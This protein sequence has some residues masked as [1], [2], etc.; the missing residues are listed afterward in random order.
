MLFSLIGQSQAPI[1]KQ[2]RGKDNSQLKLS[3]IYDNYSD[4][5][6][7][8]D[9]SLKYDKKV[10]DRW[11]NK[12][13]SRMNVYNDSTYNFTDYS[14]AFKLFVE[15]G[16]FCNQEDISNWK[17]I[18][19]QYVNHANG[20]VSAVYY[21]PTEDFYLLGAREAGLFRSTDGGDHWV[22]VTD[23]LPYPVIGIR[24]IEA[25]P[26]PIF[27]NKLVAITGDY[28]STI[29]QQNNIL[30]SSDY[31][32][33]W[34]IG[35][36]QY[37]ALDGTI[38][39]MNQLI[40]IAFCSNISDLLIG[41][42]NNEILLSQDGGITWYQIDPPIDIFTSIS[43]YESLIVSGDKAHLTMKPEGNLNTGYWSGDFTYNSSTASW[44][45][46]WSL[47]RADDL[48][49]LNQLES[50]S[51]N[52]TMDPS[53]N[54][55]QIGQSSASW[56]QH[57]LNFGC[58]GSNIG[59]WSFIKTPGWSVQNNGNVD[60][61]H[62]TFS[63]V[64]ETYDNKEIL[65]KRYFNKI[66]RFLWSG[67]YSGEF[68]LD[69]E[70]PKGA[71][72][73]V[74]VTDIMNYW[75][76]SNHPN[77]V[78]SLP[79]YSEE[80]FDKVI[81]ESPVSTANGT[82]IDA[83]GP[84][85]PLALDLDLMS[86]TSTGGGSLAFYFILE[87][88]PTEY[89]NGQFVLNTFDIDYE[90]VDS[91]TT[92]IFST[93]E[94]DRFFVVSKGSKLG[95][96]NVY[97]TLDQGD[98]YLK[99]T[100]AVISTDIRLAKHLF[101]ASPN[102]E[103]TY[104]IGGL[105]S[106][107][108]RSSG[109][110]NGIQTNQVISGTNYVNSHDDFRSGKGYDVNGVDYIVAGNDGG[111]CAVEE[112]NISP[113]PQLQSLNGDIIL[114]MIYNLDVHEKTDRIL[115]GLQDN[116]TRYITEGVN[117]SN[118]I[119]GGDGSVA[120][121]RR[122]QNP[123]TSYSYVAGDPQTSNYLALKDIQSG[124]SLLPEIVDDNISI[125]AYIGMRLEEYKL[126]PNRFIA[127][128]GP[129][130]TGTA[131]VIV[132][133]DPNQN[134]PQTDKI[135]V[136]GSRQIESIA[137]CQNDPMT[138]YVSDGVGRD[139]GLTKLYKTT[140]DGYDWVPVNATLTF[141]NHPTISDK[142]LK[143]DVKWKF[144]NAIGIDH[145]NPD[146]VYIGMSGIAEINGVVTNEYF[147]VLR[148]HED[149]ANNETFVDWSEGL[150]A[151][152]VNYLLPIES[153]NHIV[154]C[155]T[156]AGV[157]Y[158]MDGMDQWECFSNNFAKTRIT[159]LSYN[160]CSKQL[161][162]STYGR[163]VW[164]TP[165]N[166]DT[167][168]TYAKEVIGNEIWNT[169]R[170][171]R[172][173]VR[174]KTGSTLTIQSTVHIDADRRFIVEPG[175]KLI[176]DG[177]TL[178]NDCNQY[179]LGIEVWGDGSL[180]QDLQN[181]GQVITK[182]DAKIEFA[183]EAIATWKRGDWSTTGGVVT[184]QDTEFANNRTSVFFYPYHSYNP[185]NNN[186]LINLGSISNCTFTWNDEY[187]DIRP[188]PAVV[189]YHVN[190]PR[191]SGSDFIDS[192]PVLEEGDRRPTGI[193]SLDAGYK[194]IARATSSNQ[195]PHD[196]FEITGG[197]DVNNFEN[198]AYGIHA[199]NANTPYSITM[200][201][202]K[203]LNVRQSAQI[204]AVDNAVI[205]RNLVELTTGRP[206]DIAS[207][208]GIGINECT[209]FFVEG[210][211]FISSDPSAFSGGI[212]TWDTGEANNK[213]YR[214]YST[215]TSLANY[216]YG[217]NSNTTFFT[218]NQNP[219]GLT[220]LVWE[221]NH[222]TDNQFDEANFAIIG[223]PG[224]GVKLYQGDYENPAGN[225]FTD[226]N[227]SSLNAQLFHSDSEWMKYFYFDGNPP[228]EPQITI[229]DFNLIATPI[230]NE[231]SSSFETVAQVDD[232]D[233]LSESSIAQISTKL[234]EVQEDRISLKVELEENLA[235][236]DSP[237]LHELVAGLTSKNKHVVRAE[238]KQASPYLSMLL[239]EKLGNKP[240]SIFN[241][242]WYLELIQLNIEVAR[243]DNFMSFLESLE[244]PLSAEELN[245]IEILRKK[246]YTDR[247]KLEMQIMSLTEEESEAYNLLIA[248][249][250]SHN[251]EIDWEAFENL[252]LDRN[253]NSYYSE[254]AD[255]YLGEKNIEECLN[256]L[257]LIESNI[258][259]YE[260][261]YVQKEM[262]DYVIFKRYIL[263]ITNNSGIVESLSGE[264]I[265]KLNFYAEQSTGRAAIQA[266]NILCF[267][268]GNCNELPIVLPENETPLVLS[269]SNNEEEVTLF[270]QQRLKIIP[271]PSQGTF[272]LEVPNN[273]QIESL[274]ILDTQGRTIGFER[275]DQNMNR[276][277]I[278][279]VHVDS[280]IFF[281]NAKC[282]DG[283]VYTTK[284]VI[285]K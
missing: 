206:A 274:I 159:D 217:V 110:I 190:G 46:V 78:C 82:L 270:N 92:I 107:L 47:N 9:P 248:N 176:V 178:T 251:A 184:L 14:E 10:A 191:I 83:T 41:I 232:G 201:H 74:C 68:L 144:I 70:L 284:L 43:N 279:V 204:S 103:Y 212:L 196:V 230:E 147:R 246:N 101:V 195:A 58:V 48:Y 202:C 231:C 193:F 69:F 134:G 128:L 244:E 2:L 174:I 35:S 166:L 3:K 111:I 280:G 250:L 173:N 216:A 137:I 64:P 84:F 259:E 124:G 141:P 278:K 205:S 100:N 63:G 75:G 106:S 62:C 219:H 227:S 213:I 19:P 113:S 224:Q 153:E 266:R 252:L 50:T 179:W 131:H 169:D 71:R 116:G 16:P 238:L 66:P 197:Y 80:I 24:Q 282:N 59:R 67:N 218:V 157:Y 102:E 136:E 15:N 163:G 180:S 258:S 139:A 225:V 172:S 192:R 93:T 237:E 81:Y 187:I 164:K 183:K 268:T 228:E 210:N 6:R 57:H 145:D 245:E 239:L 158:R 263:K 272:V 142:N 104:Y 149:Y 85:N 150:P 109:D 267:H 45:V 152:P 96:D 156:D 52:F 175:A 99:L 86:G 240:T 203:F 72:L 98:S 220:G 90:D 8:K 221:C 89:D 269:T 194:V 129:D 165:V 155:A 170:D 243:D 11:L 61:L 17:N 233:F 277:E 254:M 33:T 186:E 285:N 49:T 119:N 79:A 91:P 27:K 168:S 154:F 40:E 115:L 65:M 60:Q 5:K 44:E 18:G 28:S 122:E 273:C 260:L 253:N 171:I 234:E 76:N 32:Q 88:D 29:P 22:S 242:E 222:G 247:G 133:R 77:S 135:K 256:I 261:P 148:A 208:Q 13:K 20:W 138:A 121:I 140:N 257:D 281:L 25:N 51:K 215:Q 73:K 255:K 177:G 211:T 108:H 235:E 185:V 53:F 39:D 229:G 189:L 120:M 182:N 94:E 127:G 249:E 226:P 1:P 198:L 42:T 188:E 276:I 23:D 54:S 26:N 87:F 4:L 126:Y 214:N 223:S 264:Q 34:S 97:R 161:Y 160:Y 117:G 207:S 236:G 7:S 30:M 118:S 151:L 114:N 105:P 241:R 271:N 55:G 123:L 181:Q 36:N 199:M 37:L 143:D 209:G 275:L 38:K 283:S 31:G 56:H 125:E 130:N 200:D 21:D 167:Y 12:Q 265:N 132:N 146:L 162:A 262:L 112:A 95:S